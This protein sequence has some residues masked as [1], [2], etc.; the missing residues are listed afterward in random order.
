MA[1]DSYRVTVSLQYKSYT[2]T[3]KCNSTL[4]NTVVSHSLLHPVVGSVPSVD[5]R[6]SKVNYGGCCSGLWQ[7]PSYG[8]TPI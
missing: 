4:M 8:V 7:L 2:V 5:R 3:L 6:G 1:Y